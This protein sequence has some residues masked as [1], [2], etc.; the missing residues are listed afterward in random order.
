VT[1]QAEEWMVTVAERLGELRER[2]MFLGGAVLGL[3]V[4]SPSDVRATQ[5]VDVVID[6]RSQVDRAALDSQLLALGFQPDRSEGAPICRWRVGPLTVDIMPTD[7]AILGFSNRWYAEAMAMATRREV[8]PGVTVKVVS[9]PYF[10]ATKLEAFLDRGGADFM[11]SHDLED[12]IAIIDGRD[13][14]IDEV[15]AASAELRSYLASTFA[16]FLSTPA[17]VDAVPGHLRGDPA[18]QARL[19]LVQQR[20]RALAATERY[21]PRRSARSTVFHAAYWA[22]S[23]RLVHPRDQVASLARSLGNAR[24][25]LNPHQIGA[26]LFALRS[27]YSRGVLLADEV[28][29]GKTIEAALVMAQK[30]AERRRRILLIAPATLRRQWQLELQQKFFLPSILLEAKSWNDRVRAGAANPFAGDGDPA[31]VICSYQFAYAKRAELA[32]TPWDLVVIDEAHRLRNVYK[33][34]K[35]KTAVGIAEAIADRRKV[36]LTAT[37]LQNSLL[38]LYGLVSILDPGVFGDVEQFQDQFVKKAG[39]AT[40]AERDLALRDRLAAVCRRTLRR[41]VRGFVDFTNRQAVTATFRNSP[42]EQELYDQVSA[43]LQRDELLVLPDAQRPLLTLVLRKLLASSTRAIGATLAKFAAR[44]EGDE[45][46]EDYEVPDD[47]ASDDPSQEVEDDRAT[48]TDPTPTGPDRAAASAGELS[49]LRRFIAMAEG[50]ARDSKAETLLEKLPAVLDSATARGARRKAVIFTESRKTQAYLADLLGEHGFRGQIVLLNGTNTDAASRQLYAAYKARHQARWDQ[51]SSGSKTADMKAAIVEEFESDRAT[52]LLAT[53]SA[54]EGVNLQFCSV[55]VNYDLPW[56]PQRIEQRIGRCHR[57]GQKSDV[58]VVNFLNTSNQADVR[59]Y[60]LLAK[61]L[62]L[63]EGVFG[64]S[65]DVLG[66]TA[67]AGIDFERAIAEIYQRCRTTDEINAAFDALQAELDHVITGG[68][69]QARQAV[70]ENLDASIHASLA[71]HRD[72]AKAALDEQQQTLLDL[73]RF[74]WAGRATFA[75]DAP[76]F[77]LDDGGVP[78]GFN[79]DWKDAAARDE[80][81]F[82]VDHERAIDLI[83]HQARTELAPAEVEFTYG[84]HASALGDYVGAAG[85]LELVLLTV[86]TIESPEQFLLV[87]ACDDAGAEVPAE[88]ALRLFTL[89]GRVVGEGG[90]DGGPPEVLASLRGQAV[91]A[92][93]AEAAVRSQAWLA[94]EAEKIERRTEDEK[95]AVAR[96]LTALEAEVKVAQKAVRVALT[97]D[98]QVAAKRRYEALKR[99]RD[100]ARRDQY[101][102]LGR[103]EDAA[104]ELTAKMQRALRERTV[105]ETTIAAIRWRLVSPTT[106]EA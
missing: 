22:H 44:I 66:A 27:P 2:V 61:K 54:A 74:A 13:A 62:Q 75:A 83:D 49:D 46:L 3:L 43:F 11:A 69:R 40:D 60:E 52:I 26:A 89:D 57:Y 1:T 38:E 103:L 100:A 51:V 97:F 64:A 35:A 58:V 68:R 92:R 32:A 101:D 16:G 105:N 56:N 86:T 87:V 12:I 85:W 76:R 18:S 17:F 10:V 71:L 79:L 106:L 88:V 21:A 14:L 65:D 39:F 73:A 99:Q 41:D 19:P 20:L 48:A 7:G 23:L 98:E 59:V 6:L 80:E 53:E 104:D 90:A 63:F 77:T 37:P 102:E 24:V 91:A 55:V 47:P 67:A 94:A 33:G 30:W 25:D 45:L 72:Q 36:L 81:F 8:A 93:V 95:Q 5:D 50:V 82:R 31:V 29:L 34:D 78:R 28:G 15:R 42:A 9:A 84:S 70:I 96:R 4:D